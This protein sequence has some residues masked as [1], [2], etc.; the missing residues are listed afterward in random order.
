MK[1]AIGYYVSLLTAGLTLTA[2]GI[3]FFTPPL[4]GPSCTANCFT[5]PYLDIASRFPRDYYW[6]YAAMLLSLVY[7]FWIICIHYW[8][9]ENKKVFSQMSMFMA[10]LSTGIFAADYFV[11]LAVVQPSLLAGEA[12]GISL[13]TQFNPH[14]VF[15]ALEEIAFILMSLSFLSL[16]PVFGKNKNEK[17]VK[18]VFLSS[19]V[20]SMVSFLIINNM[21]GI[22]REYRFEV[23]MFS[24]NWLTLVVGGILMN[25]VFKKNQALPAA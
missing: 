11:Q 22:N 10:L 6:M 18:W 25:R 5:Y 9:P 7:L 14:G 1:Q 12:D 2:F 17:A 16:V 24:I 3:A 15:I 20:L 4:S 13:L 21:F 19:F 23:A 8:S